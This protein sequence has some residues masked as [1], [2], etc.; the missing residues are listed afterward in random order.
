MNK[1]Q[2]RIGDLLLD[3]Q[4]VSQEDLDKALATQMNTG[5]RLGAVLI[6]QNAV[7]EEDVLVA[8]ANLLDTRLWDL[9]ESPPSEEALAL[10]PVSECAEHKVVPVAVEDGVLLLAMADV[11]DIE[12]LDS[13]AMRVE[14][15]VKPVLAS[16]RVITRELGFMTGL[17]D[18]GDLVSRALEV[19]GDSGIESHDEKLITAEDTAPVMTLV[20]QLILDAI[21]MKASDVHIEPGRNRVE[22]RVRMDGHLHTMREFPKRLLPM[23]VAR[24]KIMAELDISENR[25]PQDGR[26][27]VHFDEKAINVRVSFI[28]T[29]HGE[30]AVMRILDGSVAARS[31]DDLGFTQENEALFK[32]LVKRPYGM[33]LVTGPTGSGKTT[34]LY[35]A[36]NAIRDSSRNFM[37]CEDPVEYDIDGIAQSQINE[38]AGMTFASQ[39]RAILRQDPDIVLIGEIRDRETAQ[40]ALQASVTGHLVLSTLHCNDAIGALP[41]LF[42]MGAEPYLLSTSLICVVSQRL[43]RALCPSCKREEAPTPQEVALWK[44]YGLKGNLK[45][46]WRHNGCK[47]CF[48]VGYQG[49]VGVHEVLTVTPE[50]ASQI[51]ERASFASLLATAQKYGYRSIQADTLS[52][53]KSGQTSFEEARRVL[54]FDTF[55]QAQADVAA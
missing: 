30:R 2:I 16:E 45:K 43:V 12:A 34:T 28:S 17:G 19:V 25:R 49:R 32:E 55:D 10:V 20:N 3:R 46:V 54:A 39:L 27:S 6:R 15:P 23:V 40:T 52:R 8:L 53:V 13:I 51:A 21:A 37:T 7:S 44:Q 4:L 48:G 5:E 31:L 29:Y 41:R 38:K 36:L 9:V 47:Q 24:I 35:A 26:F 33:V 42:D 14:M 22:V 1:G 11:I 50:F 18:M